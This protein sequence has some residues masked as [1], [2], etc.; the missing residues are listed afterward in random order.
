MDE[1]TDSAPSLLLGEEGSDPIEDRVRGRFAPPSRRSSRRSWT[2]S[3]PRA[4]R[5]RRRRAKGWRN[6]RR[7]ARSS[8][9]SAPRGQGAARPDRAGGWRDLGMAVEGAAPRPAADEAGGGADRRRLSRRDQHPAG[10]AGSFALFEGAVGKDVVSRAWRKVKTDWDAWSARNL[11]EEDIVRLI[12]DGTVIKTRIDR[13][14]TN[15]GAGGHR[16]APGRPEGPAVDQEH[17]R[18]ERRRLA[19]VPR[20]PRRPRPEAPGFV[21]VDGA[22]A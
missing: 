3:R 4:L 20:G 17:G 7:T 14:A 15:L 12:L 18:R 9:R 1:T 6:G 5:P 10:A 16:R 19:P 11:G 8:A 13:K 22:R 21:I 2:L